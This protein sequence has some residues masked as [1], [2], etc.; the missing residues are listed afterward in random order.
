MSQNIDVV[1]LTKSIKNG[2]YCVAG[3]NVNTSE[4]VRVHFE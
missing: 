2:S 3:I 4:W 1:I